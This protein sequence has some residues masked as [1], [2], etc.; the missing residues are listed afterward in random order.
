MKNEN[1]HE[2]ILLKEA[3][4]NDQIKMTKFWLEYDWKT[5]TTATVNNWTWSKNLQLQT[6]TIEHEQKI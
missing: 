1:S 4:S 6:L 5:F 3:S 2:N